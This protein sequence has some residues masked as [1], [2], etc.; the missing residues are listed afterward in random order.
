MEIFSRYSKVLEADGTSMKVRTALALIN[1]SLEEVLSAEETEFDAPTRWALTWYEQFEHVSGPFGEAETLSKAKNTSVAVV[2]RTG[3]AE[4]RA[5][6]VRLLTRDELDRDWD[7]LKEKRLTVWK[8]AQYLVAR[9]DFGE[10]YAAEVLRAVGG[11][12]GDRARQ[13]AYLLYQ[14]ADRKGWSEDA[15]A[16][17]GLIQSWQFVA[18]LA[19]KPSVVE[20]T[21]EGV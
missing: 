16:Y 4:S 15:V 17:N 18:R 19:A 3:I 6:R 21:L 7:P 9:L 10:T 14:I 5:G 13:L 20:Q 8:V 2:E 12:M 11:G 1:E